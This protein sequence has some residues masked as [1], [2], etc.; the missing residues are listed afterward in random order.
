MITQIT[1][2]A[3]YVLCGAES[4][5]APYIYGVKNFHYVGSLTRR[6]RVDVVLES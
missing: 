2:R 6:Q 5:L 4:Q 3:T 1:P